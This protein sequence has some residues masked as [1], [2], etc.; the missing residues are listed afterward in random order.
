MKHADISI[1]AYAIDSTTPE[2][3]G[4]KRGAVS[5]FLP[6]ETDAQLKAGLIW[7]PCAFCGKLVLIDAYRN[8]REKCSC[9]AERRNRHGN[10]NWFK[11]GETIEY[12]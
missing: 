4:A 9:G 1:S 5:D 12:C 6:L 11:D 8:T 7:W 2:L 10:A 3:P